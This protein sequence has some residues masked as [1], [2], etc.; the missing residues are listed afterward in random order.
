MEEREEATRGM[1]ATLE[2]TDH[3]GFAVVVVSDWDMVVDG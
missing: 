1:A 3:S 2:K